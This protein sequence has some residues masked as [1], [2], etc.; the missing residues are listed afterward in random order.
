MKG[1]ILICSVFLAACSSGPTAQTS[2]NSST[3]LHSAKPH[4]VQHSLEQ[5]YRHWQG[6]PYQYGGLNKRGIDC[7]G[8]VYVTYRDTLGRT[9]PR[10]TQAQSQIGQKVPR[11]DLQAG[12]LVFFKTGTKQHHAGIYIGQQQFIHASSSTGVTLSRLDNSYWKKH[13]WMSRRL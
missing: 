4:R 11:N 1:I 3:P 10:T 2:S 8:F 5:H 6:T 13:Y 7:S 12:D 9:L